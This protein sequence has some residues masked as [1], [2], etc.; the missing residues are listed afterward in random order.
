MTDS[1][2]TCPNGSAEFV[3]SEAVSHRLRDHLLFLI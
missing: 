1:N 2:I 3:L